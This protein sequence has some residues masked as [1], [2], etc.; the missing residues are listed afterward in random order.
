MR[1]AGPGE[2]SEWTRHKLSAIWGDPDEDIIKGIAHRMLV[3]D[4]VPAVALV[5]NREIVDGWHRVEAARTVG[6]GLHVED[7]SEEDDLATRVLAGNMLRRR[8]TAVE[9]TRLGIL[10]LE[11]SGWRLYAHGRPEKSS[12]VDDFSDKYLKNEDIAKYCG[13]SE[14]TITRARRLI[15]YERNPRMRAIRQERLESKRLEREEQDRDYEEASEADERNRALEAE[16]LKSTRAELDAWKAAHEGNEEIVEE[17]IAPVVG[18][19]EDLLSK[20]HTAWEQVDK[21][22]FTVQ[23]LEDENV[24]L[25]KSLKDWEDHYRRQDEVQ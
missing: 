23:R 1:F 19:N 21:L 9:A 18:R 15:E 12:Q 20:L 25:R 3:G 22:R 13:V 17:K 16:E 5:G 10:T 11:A 8:H 7:L 4:Q 14:A 6:V 24:R 2:V